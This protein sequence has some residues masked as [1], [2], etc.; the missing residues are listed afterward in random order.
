MT[1]IGAL[2]FT[3][4]WWLPFSGKS[5]SAYPS[6][7]WEISGNGLRKPSY[8]FGSMHI[9]NKEVFHL[10]DSFYMAIKGCDVVA[11]EVDPN[12]W[13]PDM[14]RLEEAQRAQHSYAYAATDANY[15]SENDLRELGYTEQLIAALREE[16]FEMNGLLYRTTAPMANFQEDTYLDLY[17]YQTGRRLGK[18]GAGVENYLQSEKISIEA[19]LAELKE[20]RE[21]KAFPEGE[22]AFT[23]STKMQEAYRRGDLSLMDSLDQLL[24]S[25]KAFTEKFLYDRNVIQANSIDSILRHKSLF[26]AVGA[27]HLPGSKGVIEILR[28]KGFTLRPVK[29]TDQDAIDRERIDRLHVPLNCQI[30]ETDDGFVQCS[31]PGQWYLREESSNPSWQFADMANGSY[32]MM[33]RVKSHSGLGSQSAAAALKTV[34]SLLYDN[35]PGRIISKKEIRRNGYSGFEIVNKNHGGDLQRYLILATPAEILVFKMSGKEDYVNGKEADDFFTSIRLKEPVY[36]WTDYSPSQGGFQVSFPAIP[37]VSLAAFS[38]NSKPIWQYEAESETGEAFVVLKDNISNTHFLEEDTVDLHL[39]EESLKGSKIIAKELS[40]GFGQFEGHDCLDLEFVT[41]TGSR[42]KAKAIIRGPEYYLLLATGKKD[43]ADASRFLN[44]FHL[45]PYRY[46]KPEWYS[47]TARQ[48]TVRTPV[49]PDVPESLRPLTEAGFNFPMNRREDKTSYVAETKIQHAYFYDDSTGESVQVVAST[50]PDYFYRKDSAVFWE[51]ELHWKR[52]KADFILDAPNFFRNGDSVCGYRYTLLDTNS[53]RKVVGMAV[54]KGNTLYKVTALT[55][56]NGEESTFIRDFFSSFTPLAPNSGYSIFTSKSAM[57]FSRYESK[58]S[59]ER[60]IA[61]EALGHIPFGIGDLPELRRIAGELKPGSKN[62][63]DI[64]SQ[65]V[66]SVGR[67]RDTCCTG[68]AVDFLRQVYEASGDTTAFQNAAVEAMVRLHNKDAYALVKKWLVESPPVFENSSQLRELFESIGEDTAL[69]AAL[70]PDL[71]Q[72]IPVEGYKGPILQLMAEMADSSRLPGTAYEGYFVGLFSDAQILLKKQQLSEQKTDDE[73]GSVSPLRTTVI[74]SESSI[75]EPEGSGL[76]P[77]RSSAPRLDK[78][79]EW[80]S[81]FYDRPAV[82]RWYSQLLALKSPG[83]RQAVA[84][85]LIRNNRP[86]PDSIWHALAAD[87]WHRSKLYDELTKA[88]RVD[89]FPGEFKTQEAMAR[90]VLFDRRAEGREAEVKLVGK[91]HVVT[92][93]A[94][95]YVYFFKYKEKDQEGWLMGISG[96]QPE[97]QK[98]VNTNSTL[99]EWTGLPLGAAGSEL[100][101]FQN[102]LPQWVLQRRPSARRFYRTNYRSLLSSRYE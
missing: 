3:L 19:T 47:D 11:L 74:W 38:H 31:L 91:Q 96:V 90:S 55:D 89:L 64:K 86:V 2:T 81:P 63:I 94:T 29:M 68:P 82:A 36:R 72:L 10:S 80:L 41:V 12:E 43:N 17:I 34:D 52:L 61:R 7:L 1:R 48:F 76:R 62:Y 49:Y 77:A 25:S 58:D 83:L 69:S 18:Q 70:F 40:R 56:K 75:D 39:M 85:I 20:K 42:L 15:L 67:I 78:Y 6:I 8:L 59:A 33:T 73:D 46:A 23:I 9:S 87:D 57:L 84:L 45:A 65:L 93:S 50:L 5:Q 27:A 13:Q 66:R 92:K 79:A 28:K 54:L 24:S 44:S 71:L 102:K 88:G 21:R 26:V 16:P 14:F 101:Q 100:Q 51:N 95:G 30:A 97:N 53:S 98:A 32:Y 4:L 60:H 37:T 22:T 35:I 99:T